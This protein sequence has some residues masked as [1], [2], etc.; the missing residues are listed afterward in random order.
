MMESEHI[1]NIRESIVQSVCVLWL[2]VCLECGNQQTK[3][4]VALHFDS[5]EKKKEETFNLFLFSKW[6]K[7]GQAVILSVIWIFLTMPPP[8]RVGSVFFFNWKEKW[9]IL[10]AY[11]VKSFQLDFKIRN[12]R[13]IKWKWI[14]CNIIESIKWICITW[15]WCCCCWG[16]KLT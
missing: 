3:S 15:W 8:T 7:E 1:I 13:E 4:F 2:T 9:N 12:G 14:R 11:L 5:I 10:E 16:S 6:A